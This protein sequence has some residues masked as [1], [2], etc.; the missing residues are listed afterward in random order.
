MTKDPVCGMMVDV[1]TAPAKVEYKGRTFYFCSTGCKS[2]FQENPEKYAK[3]EMT[4]H[5]GHH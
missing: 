5:Q 2:F 3:D 1:K 4:G